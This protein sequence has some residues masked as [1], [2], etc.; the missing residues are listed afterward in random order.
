VGQ[1]TCGLVQGKD[2]LVLVEDLGK[3]RRG[4]G[5]GDGGNGDMELF[6]KREA[7]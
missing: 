3:G 4:A 7:G 2:E 6:T 5:G 1:Q